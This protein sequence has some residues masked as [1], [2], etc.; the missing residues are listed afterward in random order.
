MECL[1]VLQRW[2]PLTVYE[3]LAVDSTVS[4]RIRH[5]PEGVSFDNGGTHIGVVHK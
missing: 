5:L 4:M 3:Y 1:N 2:T